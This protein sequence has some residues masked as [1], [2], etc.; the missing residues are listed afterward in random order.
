LAQLL[1]DDLGV[2]IAARGDNR[3]HVQPGPNQ[4][5]AGPG[6]SR[7]PQGLNPPTVRGA[8]RLLHAKTVRDASR[9]LHAN[10]PHDA[11]YAHPCH[12]ARSRGI[13]APPAIP[14]EVAESMRRLDS[15]TPRAMTVRG[16]S[17]LLHAKTV[18]D[19]PRPLH[20]NT[21]HDAAYAHPCHSARSRGIHAASGFRDSA[22][23]DSEGRFAPFA[24]KDSQ[25]RPARRP[26]RWARPSCR[27][28]PPCL[29]RAFR[30]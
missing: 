19:T 3:S 20:A 1:I 5:R 17:R 9:P 26:V 27:G 18:R 7:P 14:R 23:N 29:P 16:A 21:P 10:T 13:H 12:S 4:R 11:A 6:Q 28:R 8:S 15:A 25:V 24:R 30:Q 22:R 2:G